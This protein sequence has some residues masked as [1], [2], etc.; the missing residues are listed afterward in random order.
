MT[1]SFMEL[2][3]VVIEIFNDTVVDFSNLSATYNV[4]FECCRF[5]RTQ[6]YDKVTT[7]LTI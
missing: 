4:N 7:T 3:V 1:L 5:A 6:Q 2:T